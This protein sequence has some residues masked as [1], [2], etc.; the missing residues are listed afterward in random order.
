MLEKYA[1]RP[2]VP[3]GFW[4]DTVHPLPP[5]Y[6]ERWP[7]GKH[8][9]AEELKTDSRLPGGFM[10]KVETEFTTHTT[11]HEFC[12]RMVFFIFSAAPVSSSLIVLTKTDG[13][14]EQEPFYQGGLCKWASMSMLIRSV[15][16]D[17]L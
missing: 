14:M 10:A 7:G 9:D 15:V 1:S 6:G 5:Q 12:L 17:S 13:S 8:L 11:H 16:S 2:R 3:V 4:G